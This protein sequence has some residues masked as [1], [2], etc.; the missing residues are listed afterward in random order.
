MSDITPQDNEERLLWNIAGLEGYGISEP[1]DRKQKLLYLILENGGG[2]GGGGGTAGVI[3]F[4]G[5]RGIVSPQAGDYRASQVGTSTAGKSVQDALDELSTSVAV[6]SA[7]SPTSPR[8]VRN[9]TITSKF[10]EQAAKLV[11]A[12]GAAGAVLAKTSGADHAL[13]WK[14]TDEWMQT[15]DY[16][17]DADG[18]VDEAEVADAVKSGLHTATIADKG[19][20][21]A[22]LSDADKGI[23]NGIVPLDS[24]R[25][26]LP[27]YLPDSIM[28][29]LTYGGVFNATTRV[30]ELTPAAKSI[31]DV[32]A[33]TMTLENSSQIPEGYPANAEL[34]YITTVGGTFAD[35]TFAPGDWLI[36]LSTSWK[37]LQSGNQVSS[38]NAQTGAVVL[39]S[40]DITQGSVNLYMRTTERAK[41]E[42]IEARATRDVNVVQSA[43]IMTD[44]DDNDFLR[45]T[46]KN[47]TTTDFYGG[48]VDLTDYLQKDGDA[49]EVYAP[50]SPASTRQSF[51]GSETLAALSAKITGWLE[52]IEDVAFTG[53]YDD[54]TD[55]PTYNDVTLEGQLEASDLGTLDVREVDELPVTPRANTLYVYHT[56][57]RGEPWTRYFVYTDD[58]SEIETGG[59]EVI[60]VATDPT[61]TPPSADAIYVHKWTDTDSV[62]HTQIGVMLDGTYDRLALTS[63]LITDYDDLTGKPEIDGNEVVSGDQTHESLGLVGAADFV[64]TPTGKLSGIEFVLPE[65]TP[66]N[67]TVLTEIDDTDAMRYSTVHT[68]SNHY[69]NNQLDALNTA[70]AGK[71]NLLFVE[72]LP[73]PLTRNTQYYVETEDAGVFD[74]V[75]VDSVGTTHNAGTTEIDL[76]GL[77]RDTLEVAGIALDADI[78]AAQLAAALKDVPAT[79]THK[80]ID[81]DDNTISDLTTANLKGTAIA[82]S[83]GNSPTDVKLATEKAVSDYAVKRTDNANKVYG[84]NSSGAASPY[85]LSTAVS[86]SSTDA[87]IPTAKGVYAYAVP[88]TSDAS[89]VYGTNDSGAATNYSLVT[90]M[91]ATPTDAQ[92]ASAKLVDSLTKMSVVTGSDAITLQNNNPVTSTSFNSYA[93]T[94]IIKFGK[95]CVFSTH[96]TFS[97]NSSSAMWIT[98]GTIKSGY[99]PKRNTV[100]SGSIWTGTTYGVGGH[101]DTDGYIKWWCDGAGMDALAN[102]QIRIMCIYECA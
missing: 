72:E 29:G 65:G 3:T 69:I 94:Q 30:V 87:Q 27:E 60:G 101:I 47:G 51:T 46:N 16:D 96:I 90:S 82:T 98:L 49:S 83:V 53:D 102:R 40:D 48:S 64:S 32:S 57:K 44:T 85:A 36:S 23:A 34:F 12:G 20:D 11:P 74:I 84:T 99:R 59:F 21:V 61:T 91:P 45:L 88:K 71:L 14:G 93:T 19:R 9:S 1:Q 28:A 81:A 42:N 8:P 92:L 76:G 66:D 55:Q 43:T 80:T 100:F 79:L 25:K 22:L 39:D 70:L 62:T 18:V 41:L 4:N 63:D 68:S 75:I 5:R 6:D 50:Y 17:A 26:I 31:L 37:Q 97:K 73:D 67:P 89:K 10:N 58:W 77:V 13:T 54:L 52:A 2:G 56:T 95:L 15:A 35:M 86:N 33:S 78:S 24:G 38:V 7:L